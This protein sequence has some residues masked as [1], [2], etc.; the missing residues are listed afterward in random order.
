M[1][2][3]QMVSRLQTTTTATTLATGR[4]G[5]DGS[6]ILNATNPHVGTGKGAESGLGTGTRGLG[7]VTTSSTK[8][9]VQGSDTELTAPDRDVLGSQH[10]GVGGGLITVSLDLHTT[11]NT[12]DGLTTRE[13]GDVDEGIVEGSK[14]VGN[15][16]DELS[17]TDLG[18]KGD[19]LLNLNLL[20]G[21]L[22]LERVRRRE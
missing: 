18:T 5:G 16:K 19:V 17:L 6:D 13:I 10:G 7:A 15:T 11:G 2:S 14:D 4:I 22:G 8:L 21:L 9:D 3:A 20:S 1:K 12:A